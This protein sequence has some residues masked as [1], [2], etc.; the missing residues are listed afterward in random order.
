MYL[1]AVVAVQ[2][3]LSTKA[4][5]ERLNLLPTCLTYVENQSCSLLGATIWH[6]VGDYPTGLRRF[7]VHVMSPWCCDWLTSSHPLL[8]S[9]FNI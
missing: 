6:S 4:L 5:H 7:K 3:N 2:W 9:L 1:P 8:P